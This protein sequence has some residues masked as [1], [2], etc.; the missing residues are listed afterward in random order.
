M[1]SIGG[2]GSGAIGGKDKSLITIDTVL[3]SH[4]SYTVE[5]H[6]RNRGL[7]LVGVGASSKFSRTLSESDLWHI[8]P[9]MK[10]EYYNLKGQVG[11]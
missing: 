2:V 10:N 7:M 1:S 9:A 3:P 4:S 8:K 11:G 6:D 5:S